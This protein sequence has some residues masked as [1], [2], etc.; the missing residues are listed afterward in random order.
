MNSY[1]NEWRKSFAQN[2]IIIMASSLL[3]LAG[4]QTDRKLLKQIKLNQLRW[5]Q[6]NA[7][8]VV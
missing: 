2:W 6:F 3:V 7:F 5:Q 1:G 4:S 8:I